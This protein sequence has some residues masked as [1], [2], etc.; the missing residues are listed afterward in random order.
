MYE[1]LEKDL[2]QRILRN[3]QHHMVIW[4][5]VDVLECSR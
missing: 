4:L 5:F 2:Y 3:M 1:T